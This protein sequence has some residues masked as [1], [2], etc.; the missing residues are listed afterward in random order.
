M[1]TSDLSVLD[2]PAGSAVRRFPVKRLALVSVLLVTIVLLGFVSLNRVKG[3]ANT[4]MQVTLS[5]LSD[6]GMAKSSL[7]ED[8]DRTLLAVM[9]SIPA[10]ESLYRKQADHFADES[11]QH[12][13]SYGRNPTG[14]VDVTNFKNL[15]EEQKK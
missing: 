6:A 7:A 5:N 8:F 14:P 10:D 2:A 9:T 4:I 12:F 3:K 11:K 15:L 1:P 13:D